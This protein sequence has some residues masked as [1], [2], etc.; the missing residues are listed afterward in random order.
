MC[1]WEKKDT[2]HRRGREHFRF[3]LETCDSLALICFHHLLAAADLLAAEDVDIRGL[4]GS[5]EL[6]AG[7]S[8]HPLAGGQLLLHLPLAPLFFLCDARDALETLETLLFNVELKLGFARVQDAHFLVVR[9]VLLALG[10]VLLHLLA[11]GAG[12]VLVL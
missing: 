4:V 9:G 2:H 11:E 6:R 3:V 12:G 8:A 5:H 7:R 10:L 1:K